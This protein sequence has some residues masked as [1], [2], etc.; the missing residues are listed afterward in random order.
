MA[1]ASY[2]AEE[3]RKKFPLTNEVIEDVKD[4]KEE[5]IIVDDEAPDM[6]KMLE[7]GEAKQLTPKEKKRM[8]RG[9]PIKPNKKEIISLRL[10]PEVIKKLR[11]KGRGWQTQLSKHISDWVLTKLK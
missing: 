3:L 7:K 8:Q 9:R 2:T 6:F 10:D 1:I 5:A 11:A 4:I